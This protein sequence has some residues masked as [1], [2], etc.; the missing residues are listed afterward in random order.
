[1]TMKIN[2]QMLVKIA[3]VI[4]NSRHKRRRNPRMQQ[5]KFNIEFYSVENLMNRHLH[6]NILIYKTNLTV[7][8][9]AL[10]RNLSVIDVSFPCTLLENHLNS[11]FHC[12]G[13]ADRRLNN[14]T[15]RKQQ[16]QQQQPFSNLTNN[17]SSNGINSQTFRYGGPRC[18]T[19]F[20]LNRSEVF[21]CLRE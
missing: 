18:W 17:N 2:V 7:Q 11:F 19:Q 8:K 10:M 21:R 14:E 20:R 3:Q 16:N 9:T 13:R 1:M 6:Q 5:V 4:K 15:N 12:T